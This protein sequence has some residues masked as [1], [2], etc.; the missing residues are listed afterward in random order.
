MLI[1]TVRQRVE[2]VKE[3]R[4][5]GYSKDGI[6]E[7][8][9]ASA[10]T[11]QKYIDM[12]EKDIPPEKQSARGREHEEA[13]EKL[14]RRAAL[15]RKLK[16]EGFSITQISQRTGF[17]YNTVRNY[18]SDDFS[19]VNAH[20]GK[21]REGKLAPY[22]TEVLAL[23]ADGLKYQEIYER[24]R[25][26]GY[27]GTQDAIRGFVSKERRIQ[28]DLIDT[29]AGASE[30]IDKKRLIR[31]LYLPLEKVKGLTAVQLSAVTEAY[32]IY[33][34]VLEVVYEFKAVFQSKN[35]QTLIE[36]MNSAVA[37]G[38][39]EINAFIEGIKQ[40]YDAVQNAVIYD[41]NNGLAE[42]TVNKIKVVKRIMYGRCRFPLLKNKCLLLDHFL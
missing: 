30:L 37:I 39:T 32:P 17:T 13:V 26:K 20:Y 9:G 29:G 31:L 41:Y 23:K 14:S 2:L 40:D 28:Q 15:V 4:K 35:P 22:R 24:L 8:T 7:M 33:K 3:L 18:L 1:G 42:G 34:N 21:Q 16:E 25:E 38:V 6:S 27:A 19:P 11:V 36:W 5:Q 12:P 10:R